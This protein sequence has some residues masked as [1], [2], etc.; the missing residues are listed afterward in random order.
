MKGRFVNFSFADYVAQG[1]LDWLTGA[2]LIARDMYPSLH[3]PALRAR[4]ESL[5]DPRLDLS[6]RPPLAQAEGMAELL[7]ARHGFRG[8]DEDFDDPR[9]SY[10]NEVLLRKRG[11]PISLALVYTEVARLQGVKAVGVGFPGHFLVKIV[12]QALVAGVDRS[13]WI[14]PAGGGA[15]LEGED[16]STLAERVTGDDE[17]DSDWLLPVSGKEAVHRMLSNLRR[18]YQHSGQHAR[19]LVVLHRLLELAPNSA[20]VL[21]DRGVL[22]SK[23]G[24]PHAA[25][26]DLEAYL[27]LLPRAADAQEV[28]GLI[29]DLLAKVHRAGPAE[30]LN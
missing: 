9:N 12:D 13:L 7:Y 10:I 11:L 15:I 18:C 26:A 30:L 21:R 6:G 16:L 25:L 2:L 24:A 29:D 4:L 20:S 1:D 3:V 8:A 19:L 5:S 17:V 22:Q 23:M 28:Q 27:D 14:D